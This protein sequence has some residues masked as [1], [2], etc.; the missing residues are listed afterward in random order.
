VL[1]VDAGSRL[2]INSLCLTDDAIELTQESSS[3][4]IPY[5]SI[6]DASPAATSPAFCRALEL[7]I[8]SRARAS[9]CVSLRCSDGQIFDVVFVTP[10]H[11][12]AFV[13]GV[14]HALRCMPASEAVV[15]RMEAAL[16]QPND[17]GDYPLS[18]SEH[19]E[20]DDGSRVGNETLRVIIFRITLSVP[21]FVTECRNAPRACFSSFHR[22]CKIP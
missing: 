20:F 19:F 5:G 9:L 15:E 8:I 13:C 11:K 3:T 21:P 12:R 4:C 17:E 14:L 16:L 18:S 10:S 1:L 22:A 2:S 6:R 7:K